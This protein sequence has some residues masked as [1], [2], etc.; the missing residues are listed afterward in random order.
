MISSLPRKWS[1]RKIADSGNADR[2]TRLSCRAEARSRPNGFS[3]MAADPVL[4]KR[5]ADTAR[6]GPGHGGSERVFAPERGR[7]AVRVVEVLVHRS[8]PQPRHAR[9]VCAAVGPQPARWSRSYRALGVPL[10]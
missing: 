9:Q 7:A 6:P 3:T 5:V 4:G 1:I 8:G 2:T 10:V